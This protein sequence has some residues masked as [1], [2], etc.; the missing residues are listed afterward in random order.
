MLQ[1]DRICCVL[2]VVRTNR[3]GNRLWPEIECVALFIPQSSHGVG[4]EIIVI[5][6]FDINVWHGTIKP[7]WTKEYPLIV[8]R[9]ANGRINLYAYLLKAQLDIV[10]TRYES[11]VASRCCNETMQH[12]EER[13]MGV[14]DFTQLCLGHRYITY[15]L[16]SEG[17]CCQK[18]KAVP[19]NNKFDIICQ[20]QWSSSTGGGG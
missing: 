20:A 18:I 16:R 9:Y 1:T 7:C 8:E 3:E 13:G 2:E 19:I 6:M 14:N 17:G 4:P 15:A 11:Y 5:A 12:C 10:I